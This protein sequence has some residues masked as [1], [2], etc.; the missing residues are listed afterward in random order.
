[1]CIIAGPTWQREEAEAV[2]TID[3]QSPY[4]GLMVFF[5]LVFHDYLV[6]IHEVVIYIKT[7]NVVDPPKADL[8]R[9]LIL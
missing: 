7:P 9:V 4:R 5:L 8:Q 2:W 6:I 1:M 3:H